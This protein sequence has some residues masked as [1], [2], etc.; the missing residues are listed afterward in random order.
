MSL[1]PH[2]LYC[3]HCR[4][5]S[6]TTCRRCA[7]RVVQDVPSPRRPPTA[8]AQVSTHRLQCVCVWGGGGQAGAELG[9]GVAGH[10]VPALLVNVIRT[11][12]TTSQVPPRL[13]QKVLAADCVDSNVQTP[14]GIDD[15]FCGSFVRIKFFSVGVKY[16]PLVTT[17][18]QVDEPL[19]CDAPTAMV[20]FSPNHSIVVV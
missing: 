17:P 14:R 1:W 13:C 5:S 15:R 12:G 8:T 20:S 3:V 9:R 6:T 16:R 2:A 10:V 18:S 11:A 19:S 4:I 7:T